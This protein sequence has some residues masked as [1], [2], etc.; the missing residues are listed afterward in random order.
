MAPTSPPSPAISG[1]QAALAAET[2][3]R[4]AAE[5]KYKDLETEL[6]DLSATLFEQANEM[7]AT[8]RREKAKLEERL[9]ILEERDA[10]GQ[11]RLEMVESA[12]TRI[13]RV[14]KLLDG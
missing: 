11:K 10:L 2:S 14:K 5:K 1:L 12:L 3:R 6:E 13:E 8:E 7:V 9:K 4:I